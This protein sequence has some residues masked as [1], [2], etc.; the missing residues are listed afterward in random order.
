[1]LFQ[2]INE[3]FERIKQTRKFVATL[4]TDI[5]DIGVAY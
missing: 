3:S 5:V 1:M 2:K 4:S